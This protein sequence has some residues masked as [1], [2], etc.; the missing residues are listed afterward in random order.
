MI[1]VRAALPED[2]ARIA[3]IYAP[4][5]TQG[6]VSFE[7]YP[8][9]AAEMRARMS[10]SGGLYPWLVAEEDGSLLGF[11]Y[12]G[13]FRT[14]HA[15]RFT[16]ETTIYVAKEAN[17]RGVGRRLYAALIETLKT[18]G[19]TQAVAIIALPNDASV[20][21]HET[22]GYAQVGLNRRVG[23][24]DGRWVDVGIWQIS[25]S[26]AGRPPD[27]PR[28]FAATNMPLGTGSTRGA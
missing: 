11:A 2:A 26:D 15:Y 10:A 4:S 14:R 6:A 25:L 9:D 5:V 19:F 8:P 18:Q 27:A 20:R 1:R 13:P 28:P 21:L 3:E 17:G 16:A 23:W 24:K 22:L 7:E 12:A